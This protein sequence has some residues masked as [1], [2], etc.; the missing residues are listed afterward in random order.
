MGTTLRPRWAPFQANA[1]GLYDVLGNVWEWTEDCR[2]DDYAGAPADGSA[3]R[4]GYC[5]VRVLR[6]GLLGRRSEGPPFGGPPQGLGRLPGQQPR[7]PCRPDHELTLVSYLVT[8][9]TGVQGARPLVAARDRFSAFSPR[10]QLTQTEA[11]GTKAAPPQPAKPRRDRTRDGAR[12]TG[13]ALLTPAQVHTGQAPGVI[14]R[15]NRVLATA[16]AARPDRFVNGQPANPELPPV[17]WINPPLPVTVVDTG[18]GGGS[19]PQETLP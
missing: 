18:S 11:N 4:S 6:G 19:S 7:V 9:C 3:R 13:P 12:D 16:Y 5:S 1:F 14:A 17:V 15:R 8:S 10:D 2:N